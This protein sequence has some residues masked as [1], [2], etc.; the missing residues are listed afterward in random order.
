MHRKVL[1]TASLATAVVAISVGP[2]TAARSPVCTRGQTTVER[3]PR[4]LLPLSD[5]NPIGAATTAVVRYGQKT[6]HPQSGVQRSRSPTASVDLRRN[7][8]AA[9]VC[10]SER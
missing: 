9:F 10:G 1:V 8:P 6:S 4:G 5:M 7:I 2:V 3:D